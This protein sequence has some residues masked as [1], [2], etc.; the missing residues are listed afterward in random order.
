M[1]LMFAELI[2]QMMYMFFCAVNDLYDN[3]R[4][5]DTIIR[6]LMVLMFAE[7]ININF[8]ILIYMFFSLKFMF[9]SNIYNI[10][11]LLFIYFFG[12]FFQL[13]LEE[14][15]LSRSGSA[16]VAFFWNHCCSYT[17]TLLGTFSSIFRGLDS[18][19]CI[20]FQ[21]FQEIT[22][23]Y[24]LLTPPNMTSAQSNRVCNALALL[25]VR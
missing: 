25:Q 16:S 2:R 19:L 14:R 6:S 21:L 4:D 7:L 23:V 9:T 8:R 20:H 10:C 12:L 11:D 1:V 3:R 17:G 22:S 15:N 5:S 24:R 13:F 18:F